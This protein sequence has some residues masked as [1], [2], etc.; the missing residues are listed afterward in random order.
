[1]TYRIRKGLDERAGP[2]LVRDTLPIWSAILAGAL[3]IGIGLQNVVANFG[4][5]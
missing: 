2:L 4:S 5:G 1:L 3:G